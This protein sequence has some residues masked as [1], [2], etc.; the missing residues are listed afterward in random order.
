[1]SYCGRGTKLKGK[2]KRILLVILLGLLVVPLL[3]CGLLENLT[4]PPALNRQ[5]AVAII[6][7]AGVPYIDDYFVESVGEEEAAAYGEIG[8]VTPTGT[9]D[10]KGNWEIQGTVITKSWGEC[11]TTWTLSEAESEIRLIGFSCD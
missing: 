1:M 9:W 10:G 11:L 2:A 5:Q 8:K 7:V 6:V 4:N 3:G